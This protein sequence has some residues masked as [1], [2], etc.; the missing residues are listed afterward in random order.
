MSGFVTMFPAAEIR[1]S[2]GVD[3]ARTD[4]FDFA[5]IARVR[6]LV[7]FSFY[8][9]SGLIPCNIH[10]Q[11]MSTPFFSPFHGEHR[12]LPG[13]CLA[14]C[15]VPLSLSPA[16]RQAKILASSLKPVAGHCLSHHAPHLPV[17]TFPSSHFALPSPC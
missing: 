9:W 8:H 15:C 7:A 10:H 3:D 1:H 2:D 4:R 12:V 6:Y 16:M 11:N 17:E 13:L 14:Y 5:R